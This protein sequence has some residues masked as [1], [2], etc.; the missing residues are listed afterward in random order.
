MRLRYRCCRCARRIGWFERVCGCGG[1]FVALT[2]RR[3]LK[4][5]L[6]A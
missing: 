3:M 1:V 4:A 6:A 2:R 5:R